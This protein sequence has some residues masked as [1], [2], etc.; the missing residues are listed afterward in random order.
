MRVEALPLGATVEANQFKIQV[1]L[2]QHD[3][4]SGEQLVISNKKRSLMIDRSNVRRVW[5]RADESGLNGLTTGVVVLGGLGVFSAATTDGGAEAK[6]A[7]VGMLAGIGHLVGWAID[8]PKR[9]LVYEKDR[10]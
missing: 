8:G 7:S 2:G 1:V 3:S 4:D 5:L 6:V 9:I 10:R